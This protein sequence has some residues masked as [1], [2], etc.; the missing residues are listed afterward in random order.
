MCSTRESSI[1]GAVTR[2]ERV[3]LLV[4]LAAA[5]VLRLG[6]VLALRGDVLFEH[7]VLDEDRYVED[8]RLLAADKPFEQAPFWQPPGML[9]FLGLTLRL[10]DGLLLPRLVQVLASTAAVALIFAIA[11]R[12]FDARVALV[13]AALVAGHGMLV[14]SS[15]ELLAATWAGVFDLLAVLLLLDADGSPKHATGAGLALGVSAV[16]A[17]VILPFAVVVGL[18]LLIGAKDRRAALAFGAGVVLPILPV[19]Y[20]NASFA[21][22]LVLVSTNG[23]LNFFLGNN[24]RYIETLSI[25]PGVHWGE[26]IDRPLREAHLRGRPAASSWFLDQ[27]LAFWKA[28]PA[29]ALGLYLR[30]VWLFFHAAEIPRDTD[31]YAVRS[32]SR[33]LAALVGPRPWLLP[34]GWLMP[35]ALVGMGVSLRERRLLLP[36]AFVAAQALV[37]SM[38]FVSA[39]YRVPALPFLAL[40]AVVAARDVVRAAPRARAGLLVAALGLAVVAWLPARETKLTF[41]AEPDLYRGLAHR[42]LGQ[43][44]AALAA[45]Q[46]ATTAD[47]ADPRP[48]FELAVSLRSLGKPLEAAAAWERAGAADPR[49]VRA[50]RLAATARSMA[51]DKRGAIADHAA[52][53][54]FGG[55]FDHLQCAALYLDLGESAPA[56]DA[57]RAA[58]ARDPRYVRMQAPGF[59]AALEAKAD[60]AFWGSFGEIVR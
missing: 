39:R 7:P 24:E 31:V 35:A 3:A 50:L 20:R 23:G 6:H 15:G 11:R 1:L 10:S 22:E 16:F 56:L 28:H 47:P 40:F 4:I 52:N 21:G 26:L 5:F 54:A 53:A 43:H 49:D 48:W 18:G 42:K 36:L 59:R 8:A 41:A 32:G 58:F 13:T 9:Y 38:F 46:R 34:D 27:G 19:T 12:L 60:A 51:G 37:V 2:R 55:A 57:V 25:R 17:A 29:Q 30:K 33:V 44:G 14:F 45:F